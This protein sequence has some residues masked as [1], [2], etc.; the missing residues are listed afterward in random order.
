MDV[1]LSHHT[2]VD[3]HPEAT[4][5]PVISALK[6]VHCHRRVV[7]LFLLA[8]RHYSTRLGCR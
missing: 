4:K 2:T 6:L 3:G 5:L 8:T 1:D 7:F